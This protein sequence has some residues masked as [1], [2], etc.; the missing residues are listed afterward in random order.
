MGVGRL[1]RHRESLR[2]H[3][4]KPFS[5]FMGILCNFVTSDKYGSNVLSSFCVQSRHFFV[6]RHGSNECPN[7]HVQWRDSVQ[8]EI[9][10]FDDEPG[11]HVCMQRRL[12][13]DRLDN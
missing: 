7:R 9:H 2:G 10:V 6:D 5:N 8:Y 1:V 4:M 13:F 11:K 12:L 3:F